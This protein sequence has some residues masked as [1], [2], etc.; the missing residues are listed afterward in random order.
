MDAR[1]YGDYTFCGWAVFY[2]PSTAT[3]SANFSLYNFSASVQTRALALFGN[4]SN[5]GRR[6]VLNC[7]EASRGSKVGKWSIE[8][9]V[10]TGFSG[11]KTQQ[12][13]RMH[14]SVVREIRTRHP[15]I[16]W[17]QRKWC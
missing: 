10:N 8:M 11:L 12:Q 4:S 15:Q 9:T 3:A 1:L 6:S 5:E 16:Q 14:T 17:V 7:S 13:V 2:N